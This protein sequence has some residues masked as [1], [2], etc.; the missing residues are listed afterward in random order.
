MG[1]SIYRQAKPGIDPACLCNLV[2]FILLLT[3]KK[4]LP[5]YS[6]SLP[7]PCST[8]LWTHFSHKSSALHRPFPVSS[9]NL[10]K[11]GSPHP[12]H[13]LHFQNSS[14]PQPQF[15]KPTHP[16]TS[17]RQS[18]SP[19]FPLFLPERR[20]LLS[21]FLIS[22]SFS[23]LPSRFFCHSA[24]SVIAPSKKSSDSSILS[25]NLSVP[26]NPEMSPCFPRAQ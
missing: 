5:V 23:S 9:G 24:K 18:S 25:R 2:F 20:V 16:A 6:P 19:Q 7:T 15:R 17:S 10:G 12:F 1:S 3:C 21:F 4:P 8:R 11:L 13:T 14:I 26:R 22:Y